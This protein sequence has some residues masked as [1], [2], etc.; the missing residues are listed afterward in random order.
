MEHAKRPSATKK[1][2]GRYHSVN[3]RKSTPLKQRGAPAGMVIH[4]AS[5]EKKTRR[6]AIK[7]A[8]G[9]RQYKRARMAPLREART[10]AQ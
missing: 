8:G 6:E 2:P 7:A 9:F 3:A 5:A 10:T 4:A 1:G